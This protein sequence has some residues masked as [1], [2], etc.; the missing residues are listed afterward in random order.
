MQK[1]LPGPQPPGAALVQTAQ[2]LGFVQPAGSLVPTE[3]AI[4]L[5]QLLPSFDSLMEP[6]PE[7]F[8]SAQART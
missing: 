5:P 4:Q 6:P 3:T 7:R 8:R 2:P 1:L